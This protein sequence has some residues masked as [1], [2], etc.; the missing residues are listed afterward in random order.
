VIWLIG[1]K[2]MLGTELSLVL[3]SRGLDH[4]GTDRECDITDLS[5]LRSGAAGKKIEWIVNCSAYT[6]VDRAE[7]EEAV[8]RR[9]NALGAENVAKIA[10]EIGAKMIH[11][12]TDYVFAGD[13]ER[14]YLEDDPIAPTGAYG[15]TKAEGEALARAACDRLFI[16]RTAWL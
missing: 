16:L 12:S 6:A 7:D 10:Q 8:A 5:A 11:I 13:G 4:F 15:R 2:G 14:P 3:E 9:I 1:N